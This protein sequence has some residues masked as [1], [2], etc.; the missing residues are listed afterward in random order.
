MTVWAVFVTASFVGHSRNSS[1][2]PMV[3]LAY[4]SVAPWAFLASKD[5]QSG[6]EY[7]GIS[8]FLFQTGVL[9][10]C[11]LLLF[12]PQDGAFFFT[13]VV[14]AQGLNWILQQIIMKAAIEWDLAQSS[15]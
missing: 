5:Q 14:I 1:L 11:V 15:V 13:P 9:V 8:V 12:N 3:L 2:L 7:S 6:N 4:A 10:G